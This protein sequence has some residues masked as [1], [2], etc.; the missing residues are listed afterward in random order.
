MTESPRVPHT[1][2]PRVSGV[3]YICTEYTDVAQSLLELVVFTG[4]YRICPDLAGVNQTTAEI[5]G[6]HN[7]YITSPISAT[8]D[9]NT[10][11]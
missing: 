7:A 5:T 11:L 9:N 8:L 4:V 6:N 10:L 2:S 3:F 1:E